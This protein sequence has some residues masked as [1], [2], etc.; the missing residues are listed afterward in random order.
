MVL[1]LRRIFG[2]TLSVLVLPAR[3]QIPFGPGWGLSHLIHMRPQTIKLLFV[4]DDW[5]LSHTKRVTTK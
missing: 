5:P 3:I 2:M 1:S 4:D